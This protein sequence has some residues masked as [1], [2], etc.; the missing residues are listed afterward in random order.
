MASF[1]KTKALPPLL[2]F[3]SSQ[4]LLSLISG[5]EPGAKL[6]PPGFFASKSLGNLANYDDSNGLFMDF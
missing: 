1:S 2:S 6:R 5:V 3:P 4:A